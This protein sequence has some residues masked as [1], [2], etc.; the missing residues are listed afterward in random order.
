MVRQGGVLIQPCLDLAQEI[1]VFGDSETEQ[2]SVKLS[3]NMVLDVYSHPKPKT[4]QYTQ[5]GLRMHLLM[6]LVSFYYA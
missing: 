3:V 2:E 6:I 4:K 1:P 5:A